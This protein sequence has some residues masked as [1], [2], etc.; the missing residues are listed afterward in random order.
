MLQVCGLTTALYYLEILYLISI[1]G[2]SKFK[3]ILKD[4]KEA[5]NQLSLKKTLDCIIKR[6]YTN[7]A[8]CLKVAIDKF[9]KGDKKQRVFY[10]FINGFD[11]EYGLYNQ[12]KKYIFNDKNCS[13]NFIISKSNS[14]NEEQSKILSEFWNK[15]KKHWIKLQFNV[16]LIETTVNKI[17]ELLIVF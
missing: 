9:P 1:I 5:H 12:W 6:A 8:S 7:I 10:I 13:F 2:D 14:L 3:I 11:E 16:Q 15:F 4:F 17:K